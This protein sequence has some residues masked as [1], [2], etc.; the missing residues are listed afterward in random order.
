MGLQ[1]RRNEIQFGSLHST[2]SIMRSIGKKDGVGM[3]F[4][5]VQAMKDTVFLRWCLRVFI[6]VRGHISTYIK[7][8]AS[9][10]LLTK[11]F[12][13]EFLPCVN[14]YVNAPSPKPLFCCPTLT[15]LVNILQG[16]I[17]AF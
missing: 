17:F 14:P 6:R 16:D 3:V 15:L 1:L 4:L 8:I 10:P 12:L 2:K 5:I 7:E 11:I 13:L 9:F